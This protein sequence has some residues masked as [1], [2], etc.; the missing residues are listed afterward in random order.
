MRL[1]FRHRLF[2]GLLALG[3]IP[4]AAALVVLALQIRSVDPSTGARAAIDDI[5]ESG[6]DLLAAIDTTQLSAEANSA[7][8]AHTETLADRTAMARRAEVLSRV[9]AGAAGILALVIAVAVVAISVILARRWSAY[10][11]APIEELTNWVR[12]IEQRKPLPRHTE[13]RGAPEFHALR[14]ALSEMSAA[15]TKVQVQEIERE[16][17]QAFRETA[18]QVAHEMRG[19]L[20]SV[21]LAIEQLSKSKTGSDNASNVA[22]GV[23]EDETQRLELLAQEFSDFGRLPEGPEA[24]IDVNEMIEGIVSSSIPADC[25]V[26]QELEP[27]LTV[28][29]HFEPLRRAVQNLLRNAVEASQSSGVDFSASRTVDDEGRW[30]RIEIADRGPGIAP[31]LRERI[32]EPYFTTKELGTGLG[33]AI[34]RQTVMAHGGDVEVEDAVGGGARFIV[35]LPEIEC[36]A[37]S[38]S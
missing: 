28:H 38:S 1:S 4:L 21:R 6:R 14:N 15:L 8:E 29:G 36:Q 32:F 9:A 11:S 7:L 37:E 23:L 22:V 18:R 13:G 33:L 19:P 5:A 16:R 31:D 26:R 12:R 27:G 30:V 35:T 10:V 2:V 20:T 25:P 3:T 34:V 24:L 17:L